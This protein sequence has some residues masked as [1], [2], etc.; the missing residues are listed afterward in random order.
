[1]SDTDKSSDSRE[2]ARV[3]GRIEELTTLLSEMEENDKIADADRERMQADLRRELDEAKVL[4]EERGYVS[5]R[6]PDP[7]A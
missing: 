7:T 2:R 5:S 6:R 1:M 3:I 4:A